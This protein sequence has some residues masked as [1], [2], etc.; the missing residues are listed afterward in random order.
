M[1]NPVVEK[2]ITSPIKITDNALK[3][4]K[5]IIAQKNVPEG[6][7]LRVGVQ[8]GGCAGL[9]YQLGFDKPREHDHQY[10]VGGL[11]VIVD[12]R[13]LLYLVGVEIDFQDGLNARGF[14]FNNPNAKTT[15]GCG[16]SFSTH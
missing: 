13:H 9:S 14:T 10:E 12:K 5:N 6:Y 8:G 11:L 3:E 16:S 15:C 2:T 4:I 1:E 7:G